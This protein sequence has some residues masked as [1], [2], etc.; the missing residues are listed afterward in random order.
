MKH[1]IE[2]RVAIV[3]GAGGGLGREHALFLARW[4]ARVVINDVD[5]AAAEAVAKE[6]RADGGMAIPFA[7][8]VTDAAYGSAMPP[9]ALISFATDSAAAG[10]TSLTTTRAPQ[11]ARNNACSRP[12]P[13]PAPVTMATRPSIECFISWVSA[14][15]RWTGIRPP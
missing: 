10:L 3:T 14:A 5:L 6:I 4:G 2:G 9:S 12:S 15:R 11:R 8:S 7:A 1:S 13:P